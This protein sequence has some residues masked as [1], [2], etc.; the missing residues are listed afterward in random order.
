MLKIAT[1]AT[2]LGLAVAGPAQAA[3]R[4]VMPEKAGEDRCANLRGVQLPVQRRGSWRWMVKTP[5]RGDCRRILV[6]L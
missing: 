2:L 5:E 4:P 3:D 1:L 6:R